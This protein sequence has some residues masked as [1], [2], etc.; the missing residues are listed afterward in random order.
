[1]PRAHRGR[2]VDGW[3]NLDKPAGVTSNA[4]LGAARR[5]FGA[6][7][8]G[9]GGTL[10]P[11]ASGVL[12]IA[13]GEATKT[14][15]FVMNG[16][17]SYR[18]A[19]AFGSAT[20][21]DDEEGEITATSDVRPDDAAIA[22]MLPR[23]TGR[24]VQVPPRFS[25]IK[26]A[27]KR[28][29]ALA[30][31]GAEVDI[32][33]REVEIRRLVLVSRPDPDHAVLAADCGKGTYV[34]ALARD[35]AA[36]LGTVGHVSELRRTRCGPFSEADAISLDNLPPLGHSAPSLGLLVPVATVLD[37][38]PALAV[39]EAE[40][41]ALADGQFL[42]LLPILRRSPCPAAAAAPVLRVMCG[43]RVAALAR[44]EGLKLRPVRILHEHEPN[45]GEIDVDHPGT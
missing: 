20:A 34:R 13:F 3:L 23:F 8:A 26:I 27:G 30:R 45:D 16:E 15:A 32:P 6:A 42:E 31:G 24:I 40:A 25:A 41:H 5:A 36:A 1:M 2:P 28:A 22:A 29:Y 14:V 7:K 11:L 10:D 33:P 44:A 43:K 35:I 4:A 37:D 21:T 17:K 38:I 39:T 9:H 12:P 18:F 19:V